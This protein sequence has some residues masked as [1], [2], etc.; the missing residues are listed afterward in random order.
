MLRVSV[1]AEKAGVPA[2]S[3]V[4]SP[5]LPIAKAVAKGLGVEDP[6]IAEYPGVPML[7]TEAQLHD[8]VVEQ[9][10]PRIVEG[11]SKRSSGA[12]A[13]KDQAQPAPRDIVF[14]GELRDVSQFFYEHLWTDGLPIVPPTLKA[15]DAFMQ[16]TQRRPEEVIG[17][18]LPE[19]R[20]ATVWNV[21]VNG[22]M[23]G[24]R[25]EYMPVLLAIIEAVTDP[26]FFLED[27]GA[28]P[29]WEPLIILNGPI[30]RELDFNAGAGVMRVGRQANTSIGRFLRL[31]MRNVPGQRIPPGVTDKASIGMTFNV[32]LAENEDAV[33]AVGWE[34]LSVDRGFA[35]GE[36]VVTVQS[37]ASITPATYTGGRDARNHMQ[38]ITEVIG[39][40]F[41]YWCYTGIR[42]QKWFPLLVLGPA[43]AKVFADDGWSKE[44]IRGHLFDNVKMPAGLIEKY[45]RNTAL[46]TFSLKD[47]VERGKIPGHYYESDDPNRLVRV[48]F[49]RE[50]INIVV[51]GDPGRNQSRGYVQSHRHGVPVSKRIRLPNDWGR[52]LRKSRRAG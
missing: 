23:A 51:S 14:R 30:I 41:S 1:A 28:T 15:V 19:Y 42:N 4:A 2:V 11:L 45:G 17:I 35:R 38:I 21:A 9:L 25:P 16:F 20:E 40:A 7:D 48:F 31:F 18:C 52:L 33:A 26:A 34:P 12:S 22:V 39:Q 36:N 49:K 6:V 32:V 50:W 3:I 10:L 46:S 37:C 24:C 27:A 13:N 44:D 47:L 43:V 29:G 5:F 8:H